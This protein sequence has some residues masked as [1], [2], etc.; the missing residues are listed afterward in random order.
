MYFEFT[1]NKKKN[2]PIENRD[3]ST[4]KIRTIFLTGFKSQ[5]ETVPPNLIERRTIYEKIT[6]S[7]NSTFSL[8]QGFPNQ[9]KICHQA[10][11]N[12][13]NVHASRN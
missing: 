6:E 9:M 8:T 2:H 7:C 11:K 3:L 10:D 1:Y 13:V 5:H 4:N 12:S